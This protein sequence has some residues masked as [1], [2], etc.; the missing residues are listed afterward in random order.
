M[1]DTLQSRLV[2]VLLLVSTFVAFG[3]GGG[4]DD[5][6][7][8]NGV[9][10][11]GEMCDGAELGSATC[12]TEG[13]GGGELTCTSTCTIDTSACIPLAGECGNGQ[14]DG[15]EEC[16]GAN[17]N[18]HT[19]ADL[20]F[21]GGDLSCTAACQFDTRGCSKGQVDCGNGEIDG[22]E[23][24]DG[25]NLNGHTC[26]DLGFDGGDLSCTAACQFDTRGCSKWQVACGNGQIDGDEECDG[27]NM[28]GRTCETQGFER[29][30]LGCTQDCLFDTSACTSCGNGR[31]DGHDQCDGSNYGGHSCRS[32]GFD[33]GSLSCTLDCQFNTSD[34]VMFQEDCGNGEI[35]S[36]EQCDGSNLN[37][38]TCE[39]LGF[40][41]GELA[42]AA[43]CS[44]DMAGCTVIC[45]AIDL[46]TFNG[47]MIQR[48][49][50]SCTSTAHYDARGTGS[51]CL[52]YHSIGNEIVYSL[53]VPAGEALKVDM[54]PTDIDASLWVTTDCGDIFGRQCVAGADAG[55]GGESETLVFTN[56]TSDTV[57]YYII[58]DAYKD[59]D[60]FTLTITE[61]PY[62]GNGIV[63][64]SDECDGDDFNSHSCA[65]QGFDGGELGCTEDCRFDTTGCTYDCRAVD[66]GTVTEDIEITYEDSCQGT[67]I[68][69]AQRGSNCTGYSTGGKEMVYRITLL[70]GNS[71]QIV[72]NGE[73]LDTSLWVT[74]VCTDVTGELCIAG[75][76]RFT[77]SDNQPEELSITN[78]GA[79]A[80]SYYIVAD[81]N[82]GCG[83]FDLS[84]RV[85]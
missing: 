5:V 66:L 23:E 30:D 65:S 70:A 45:R 52:N 83:V 12:L 63:D 80:M 73:D 49:D 31:V 37:G 18:G 51:G 10:E 14:I 72:M 29:G 11:T 7:C 85:Q 48:T 26:A 82:Y 41:G 78:D 71:V 4:G 16:D 59:C 42:C 33:G 61:A 24:C 28:N 15:D 9:L 57:T 39:K 79:D 36:D 64:G 68:Y 2:P 13:F 53:T 22:D 75:A 60:E 17:L 6:V 76:D 54:V 77:K 25:A 35:D 40:D 19:C 50:D 20:G 1:R 74:T 34:C 81:A 46:G 27:E 21:D 69:D 55:V 62:C 38:Q 8:G 84:I 32:L 47:T 67:S 3:C 56:D 44:F 58:A 43:D